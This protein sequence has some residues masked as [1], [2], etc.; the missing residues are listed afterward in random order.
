MRGFAQSPDNQKHIKL[1]RSTFMPN[2]KKDGNVYNNVFPP[3]GFNIWN[4]N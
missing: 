2:L 3:N 4:A 1:K